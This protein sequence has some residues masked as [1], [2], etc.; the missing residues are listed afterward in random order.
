MGHEQRMAGLLEAFD[1][2]L[3]EARLK[4]QQANA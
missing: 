3:V 4:G 2:E 1:T